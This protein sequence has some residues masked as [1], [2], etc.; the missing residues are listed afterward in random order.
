[1]IIREYISSDCKEIIKLFYE[2]VHYVNAKDYTDV[3]LSVWATGTEDIE[4]WNKSLSEH[5][6]IITIIENKIV[7]FGDVDINGYLDRLYVHKDYQK[8]GIAKAICDKLENAVHK[9]KI[10]TFAS[11]TAKP[12][13]KNRGYKVI[14]ENKVIRNGI[15][16]SNFLMEKYIKLGETQ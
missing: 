6:T 8:I 11:I 7:G 1:M 10:T 13:F 5:Y 3:Q 14:R 9:N 12:F 2:T 4:Q 15:E 16:L